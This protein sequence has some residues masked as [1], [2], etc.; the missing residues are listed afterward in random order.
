MKHCVPRFEHMGQKKGRM[1]CPLA[2]KTL[3]KKL[4]TLIE[5]VGL[6]I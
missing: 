6:W 3:L 5:F 1:S 2:M 4:L